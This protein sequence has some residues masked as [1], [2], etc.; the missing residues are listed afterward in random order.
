MLVFW[1]TL[2]LLQPMVLPPSLPA[3]LLLVV[4]EILTLI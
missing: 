1:V 3:F 2:C 4:G